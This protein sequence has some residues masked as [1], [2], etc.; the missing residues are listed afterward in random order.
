M[1][2]SEVNFHILPP[3]YWVALWHSSREIEQR[4]VGNPGMYGVFYHPGSYR[5]TIGL[6]L[7]GS[8]Q[9]QNIRS[10]AL[11]RGYNHPF[12]GYRHDL[13]TQMGGLGSSAIRILPPDT[14]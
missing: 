6:T 4:P 12:S 5:Q 11:I 1:A 7:C 3:V 2:E 10:L 14:R 9:W 13:S 8:Q